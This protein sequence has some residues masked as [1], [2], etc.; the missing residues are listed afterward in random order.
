MIFDLLLITSGEDDFVDH[1]SLDT[2]WVFHRWNGGSVH[3]L[4]RGFRTHVLWKG[5]NNDATMDTART[6]NKSVFCHVNGARECPVVSKRRDDLTCTISTHRQPRV[7]NPAQGSR[8]P[9]G[10]FLSRMALK[11]CR[12]KRRIQTSQM[13]IHRQELRYLAAKQHNRHNASAS[14]LTRHRILKPGSEH[15]TRK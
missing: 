6:E 15:R 13:S 2:A 3:R 11:N 12:A 4:G 8:E 1:P 10:R 5:Q 9:A 7:E 14:L